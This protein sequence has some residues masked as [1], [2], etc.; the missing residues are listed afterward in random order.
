MLDDY[1]M[2]PAWAKDEHKAFHDFCES[3]GIQ[4]AYTGYST[5]T[6]TVSASVVLTKV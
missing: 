2:T 4:F 5:D 1:L 6:P 3:S